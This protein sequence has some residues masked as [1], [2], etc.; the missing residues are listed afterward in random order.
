MNYHN[1]YIKYKSKYNRLKY[2]NSGGGNN[3]NSKTTYIIHS[4]FQKNT[5]SILQD[6]YLDT[7]KENNQ[8]ILGKPIDQIFT[9]MIYRDIP[10]ESNQKPYWWDDCFILS[11]KILKDKKFYGTIGLGF[12]DKFED[13][14]DYNNSKPDIIGKGKLKKIPNLTKFKSKLY[15]HMKNKLYLGNLRFMH[16]HE[17]LFKNRINLKKYCIGLVLWSK[18]HINYKEII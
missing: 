3:Y 7:S 9:Q 2:I 16:S 11:T 4:T 15:Q 17:I 8:N 14:M 1:K 5:L 10:F 12:C 13:C 6:G 18:K